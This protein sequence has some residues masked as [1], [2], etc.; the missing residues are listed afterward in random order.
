MAF[1]VWRVAPIRVLASVSPPVEDVGREMVV[2][3]EK[4]ESEASPT[5]TC[6]ASTE[7]LE[8]VP[9]VV[10]KVDLEAVVSVE[11]A[12]VGGSATPPPRLTQRPRVSAAR[13][14]GRTGSR[15]SRRVLYASGFSRTLATNDELGAP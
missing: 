10:E 11:S 2:S 6:V 13:R 3:V 15:Q 9:A 7:T 14:T 4:A 1:S 8:N 5:V 12:E